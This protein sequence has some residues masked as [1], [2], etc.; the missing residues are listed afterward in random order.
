[1]TAIQEDLIYAAIGRAYNLQ[2]TNDLDKDYEFYNLTV[3]ADETLT[4]KEE[5]A[6]AVR[7]LNKDYDRYKVLYNKGT[8]R[9]CEN[10]NKECLAT[11]FCEYCVR[12]YLKAKFP[13]WT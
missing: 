1:M 2:D 6:E 8:K 10:C 13:N 11:L 7:R 3:L 5:K 12:N 9:I 4:T